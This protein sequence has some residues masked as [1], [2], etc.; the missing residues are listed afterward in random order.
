MESSAFAEFVFNSD[1]QALACFDREHK[2]ILLGGGVGSGK[3]VLHGLDALRRSEHETELLHGIFTNTQNQLEKEVIPSMQDRFIRAGFER[4][5]FDKRPPAHWQREWERAGIE[6]P[7]LPR[8]RG[9]FTAPTGYHALCGTLFNQ[10]F[11]QYDTLQFG[12]A[13]IE[14]A[15]NASFAAVN[16]IFERVRCSRGGGD[17]CRRYHHHSK[18]L[19]FNPPR[20]PH[21]WLYSFL[22]QLEE[23]ARA[24]YHAVPDGESCECPRVH[25]PE[26]DHR[27]WPLLYQGIGPAVLYRSQTADNAAN[28]D[29]DYRSGLAANMSRDTARRR[30]DGEILRAEGST[31]AYTEFTEENIGEVRYD[32]E[33]PLYLTLDFNAEPRV[34]GFWHPLGRKDGVERLGKFGEFFWADRL[35]DRKFAEKLVRGDRGDGF[36]TQPKYR[37]EDLRGLPANWDGLKGHRGRIVAFGDAVGKHRSSHADNLE[38]SWEIVEQVFRKL[39]TYS[40]NVPDENPAPR[41]R[42]DSVNGKFCNAFGVR[43]AIVAPRCEESIRDFEQVVWDEEGVS[44]REWRRGSLG[45]EWHRSHLSDADGY[46]IHR[47]FPLGNEVVDREPVVKIRPR[48][49]R[50]R[51]PRAR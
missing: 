1:A 35:S 39:R 32:P 42:V 22:D 40:R 34:A 18:A 51:M 47:L 24:F 26:L 41:S 6:V 31:R 20:G 7:S 25:G 50:L 43:A 13:R 11:T 16:T 21:P 23:N 10:S 28:L 30:L 38:S 8:Y 49:P 12:S 36:D 29:D 17:R 9:I 45:T 4:P 3:S 44:I 5:V 46:M 27:H 48:E 15:T 33:A 19:I 2:V 14:E 37:D